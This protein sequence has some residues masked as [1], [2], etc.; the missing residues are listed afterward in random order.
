MKAR[1]GYIIAYLADI[2]AELT[3]FETVFGFKRRFLTEEGD[4]GELDTGKCILAFADHSLGKSN[5]PTGYISAE[6]AAK[7]LGI[8]I[9]I[10]VDDL[11]AAHAAAIK[12]GA[13]ELRAPHTTAWGQQVTWL[14]SPQGLLFEIGTEL[15][16]P[17]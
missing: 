1:F 2:A 7:P 11:P 3:F 15:P 10:I 8:E 4:Y 13:S 12:A 17:E 6:T 16:S 5:L 9:G 14:R